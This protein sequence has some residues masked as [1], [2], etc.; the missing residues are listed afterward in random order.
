MNCVRALV[1][2]TYSF[3]YCRPV[4]TL[5][6]SQRVSGAL[7]VLLAPCLCLFPCIPTTEMFR[8]QHVALVV[9]VFVVAGVAHTHARPTLSRAGSTPSYVPP[10][11]WGGNN[12]TL[13]F[14]AGVNMTDQHVSATHPNWRFMYRYNWNLRASRYDHDQGQRDEVCAGMP[15]QAEGDPCT[16]LNAGN[17]VLYLIY[18]TTGYAFRV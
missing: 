11:R 17:S 12:E 4:S 3:F 1:E 14:T 2:A 8:A 16:V 15:G 18:P 13:A 9:A 7:S 5:W 10:P 6:H